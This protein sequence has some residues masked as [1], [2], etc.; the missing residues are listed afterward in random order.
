MNY[1]LFSKNQLTNV[2]Q[3]SSS[4]TEHIILLINVH[5]P[6]NEW[7]TVIT[8]QLSTNL[9]VSVPNLVRV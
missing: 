6:K 1:Q 8:E 7:K 2:H 5:K 9:V 3:S 4:T